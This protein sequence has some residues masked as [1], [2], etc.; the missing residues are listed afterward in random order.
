MAASPHPPAWTL[1][2]KILQQNKKHLH[3]SC[4]Q[5]INFLF[6][7]GIGAKKVIIVV[8]HPPLSQPRQELIPQLGRAINI[9]SHCDH[10]DCFLISITI[11]SWQCSNY[12]NLQS[13]AQNVPR[14]REFFNLPGCKSSSWRSPDHHTLDQGESRL[15]ELSVI[16]Q[17]PLSKVSP[18]AWV[19]AKRFSFAIV[20]RTAPRRST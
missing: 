6:I 2:E 17:E 9:S 7:I 10:D 19:A 15:T 3:E 14:P 11:W 8:A 4:H 13:T 12:D 5:M 16:R 20:S 1:I 18:A